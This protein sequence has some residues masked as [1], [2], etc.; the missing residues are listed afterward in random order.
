MVASRLEIILQELGQTDMMINLVSKV[1]AWRPNA[2]N[3]CLIP[4]SEGLNIQFELD[5]HEKN[6]VVGC[7]LGNVPPSPYRHKLFTEALRS[8]GVPPPRYGILA[9]SSKTQNLILFDSLDLRD[10]SGHKIADYLMPFLDKAK[11]W[12]EAIQ[13]GNIPSG[14][15]QQSS[16]LNI[17]GLK[18]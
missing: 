11:Q 5:K 15:P 8:N 2:S 17:F 3:T 6:L 7:V 10:L 1:Q 13:S 16:G 12:K 18:L 4:I 14:V 9:Y